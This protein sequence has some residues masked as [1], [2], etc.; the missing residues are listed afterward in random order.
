MDAESERRYIIATE[1]FLAGRYEQALEIWREIA[2]KYPYNKKVQDA[3]KNAED[4][5][6]R[7]KENQE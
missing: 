2:E 7:T 3:I 4:R 1:H 5:I 6:R